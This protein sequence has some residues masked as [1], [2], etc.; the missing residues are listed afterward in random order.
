MEIINE[1]NVEKDPKAFK[2]WDM[3][4]NHYCM[5]LHLSQLASYVV[6][7]FGIALPIIMWSANKDQSELVD[8]QGKNVLNWNISLLIYVAV[9]SILCFILI[10][11]PMLL[12]LMFVSIIFTII[13]AIKAGD[14]VIYKYPLAMTFIK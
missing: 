6:P 12:A 1:K 9:S 7:F 5:L 4:Q 14:G 13:G 11:I 10:G 8:K 2:P 3:E